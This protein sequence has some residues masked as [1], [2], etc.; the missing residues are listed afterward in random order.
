MATETEDCAARG[1]QAADG[2]DIH[3]AGGRH[4]TVVGSN[5]WFHPAAGPL[6]AKR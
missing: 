1:P 2:C 4:L 3:R 6:A 5:P